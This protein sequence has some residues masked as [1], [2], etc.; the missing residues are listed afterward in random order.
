MTALFLIVVFV[1]VVV[2]EHLGIKALSL[3]MMILM[4][5]CQDKIM[6]FS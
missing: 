4:Y 1:V 2:S 6:K 5:L 3:G